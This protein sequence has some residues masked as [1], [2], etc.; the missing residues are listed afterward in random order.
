MGGNNSKGNIEFY[1]KKLKTKEK[2]LF[3]NL[4]SSNVEKYNL[5]KNK[6]NL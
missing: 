5:I 6:Y 2:K 3:D 1:Y 4:L